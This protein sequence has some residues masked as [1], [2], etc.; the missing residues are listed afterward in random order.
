MRIKLEY[1][2]VMMLIEGLSAMHIPTKTHDDVKRKL[3]RRLIR[4]QQDYTGGYADNKVNAKISK[5]IDA[6]DVT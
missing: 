6:L 2:E 1:I 3:T 4:M 5:A